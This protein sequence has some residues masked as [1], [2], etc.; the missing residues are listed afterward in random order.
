LLRV[1]G[2]LSCDVVGFFADATFLAEA[3]AL[4]PVAGVFLPLA[5]LER[6]C[7]DDVVGFSDNAPLLAEADVLLRVAGVFPPLALLERVWGDDVVGFS[8]D[9]T[10]LAEEDLLRAGDGVVVFLK[11]GKGTPLESD[12][13][14]FE[15]VLDPLTLLVSS[16]L[17]SFFLLPLAFFLTSVSTL[18]SLLLFLFFGVKGLLISGSEDLLV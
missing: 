11:A 10:F 6:V 1:A 4:L 2:V 5:L 16:S 15:L 12:S 9:A 7:G 13:L 17:L 18:T 3:V 14:S 8:N